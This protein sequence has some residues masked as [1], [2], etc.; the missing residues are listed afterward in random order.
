[1][2]LIRFSFG[3]RRGGDYKKN[4]RAP[5]TSDDCLQLLAATSVNL[6]LTH[7]T[8]SRGKNL[9]IFVFKIWFEIFWR[10][11]TLYSTGIFA[12]RNRKMG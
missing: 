3:R 8:F 12:S 11:I 9:W 5:A 2:P 1:M 7:F 10:D 4:L 6:I